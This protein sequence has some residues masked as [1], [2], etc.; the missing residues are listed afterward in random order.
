[1][2]CIPDLSISNLTDIVRSPLPS[3]VFADTCVWTMCCGRVSLERGK[4]GIFDCI[5]ILVTEL[6]VVCDIK[7]LAYFS[8]LIDNGYDVFDHCS[9][10]TELQ[11]M[12]T[13]L[14]LVQ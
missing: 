10:H 13:A 5:V 7:C 14:L 11:K 12:I 6:F 1:M 9:S 3:V 4:L 8:F 2:A